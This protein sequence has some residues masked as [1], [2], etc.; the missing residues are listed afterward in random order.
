MQDF[1]WAVADKLRQFGS[2]VYFGRLWQGEK[3]PCFYLPPPS[4]RRQLLPCG[5]VRREISL[6]LHYY[7]RQR[8]A[9][10][11]K[12]NETGIAEQTRIGEGLVRG[13]AE[14]TGRQRGYRG[15]N[16]RWQPGNDFLSFQAEYVYYTTLELEAADGFSAPPESAELMKFFNIDNKK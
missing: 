8:K 11:A 3:T 1:L 15:R 16:L 14:L 12:V 9:A 10:A 7:P 4:L 5:R 2:P 6:A 13:M